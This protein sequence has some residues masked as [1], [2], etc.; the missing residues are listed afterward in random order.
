ME[1]SLYGVKVELNPL[2]EVEFY[3]EK[4]V[5]SPDRW[6]RICMRACDQTQPTVEIVPT[7]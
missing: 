6:L 3:P 5:M 4:I 7:P 2:V 1:R